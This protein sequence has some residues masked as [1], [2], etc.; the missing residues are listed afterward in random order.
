MKTPNILLLM[1][2][3]MAPQS[4][5]AYGHPLVRTPH[6]DTLA[7]G[8]TIF[9]NAY[10]NSPLCAPSRL[11]MMAGQL[12]SRI[13]AYDN[14]ADFP[15]DIPT[16]AHYLRTAGYRTVLSGKMHFV[17]ADQLHGFEER[18]TT[19]IY[20]GD[21]GWTP[22]WLDFETRPFWYH[23]MQSV[24]EAGVY[25][26]TLEIDY[27]EEVGYQAARSLYDLARD[28]DP[29]PFLLT[30]SFIQPHDPYMT[31]RA[32]W[33]RYR[34][35]DIDMPVVPPFAPDECDPYTRRLH[36]ICQMDQYR[37]S[38]EHVRNARHAYYAMTSWLDD[39]V[40]T[41][42]EAL[43][44][45]GLHDD[46]LIM[47]TSDHGD[48][49]GERGLWYKM[50]F[51]ERSVRVPL[52]LYG[53]DVPA[54]TRVSSNVSL[55]D[56]LPTMVDV[57]TDGR[58]AAQAAPLDG[59]SLVPLLSDGAARTNDLV[60]SEYLAE[61]TTQPAFMLKRGSCKYISCDGDPPQLYD[62]GEDPDEL[63]NV[64]GQDPHD[65]TEAA[66][67]AEVEMRWD[68]DVLRDQIIK[69]QQRRRIVQEALLEG[70]VTPWDYQPHQAASE[71]YNRNYGGEL[72][73]SDRRARIPRHE[74]PAPDA[75]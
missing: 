14:A 47:F 4:L 17:G 13:G 45:T 34:H 9:E 7:E 58:G 70:R 53:P 41:L 35:D 23:N 22:D 5:A 19:D 43:R 29:R 33:D 20:P 25:E 16:F 64:S 48:M 54:A 6:L 69:S 28:D 26:R 24:V 15:S 37:I 31:P 49:L 65:D 50:S 11:S 52:I 75:D 71:R 60:A 66:F 39:K 32:Y 27:D 56:L 74:A 21:Y 59:H 51:F 10:C 72:Y 30:V 2:D 57:A 68:S 55:V 12:C 46:T 40:G 36:H 44:A 62:L 63:E 18:M 42:L 38:D 67:A 8:G 73:D 3:Q 61:G 1:F